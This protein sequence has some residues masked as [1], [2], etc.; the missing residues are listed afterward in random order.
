ML[1]L[2]GLPQT[3]GQTVLL[4]DKASGSCVS[5]C[6]TVK[7]LK[8]T[9]FVLLR[10]GKIDDD[11]D[12][13]DKVPSQM[14]VWQDFDQL[15]RKAGIKW[16]WAKWVKQKYRFG[17]LNVFKEGSWLKVPYAFYGKYFLA[18]NIGHQADYD[19]LQ[20]PN[21]AWI[22]GTSTS[23]FEL[24]VLKRKIMGPCWLQ[25]KEPHIEHKGVHLLFFMYY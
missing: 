2:A 1:L 3:R 7:N 5:C 6:V 17:E 11:G 8:Q 9:L 18:L 20:S 25:I 15:R 23:A 12:K 19:S 16:W 14:D 22:F 13:M 21:I 4:K 24:L 10:D